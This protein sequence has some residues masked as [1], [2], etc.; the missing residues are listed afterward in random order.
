M[1]LC[2]LWALMVAFPQ[3]LRLPYQGAHVDDDEISWIANNTEKLKNDAVRGNDHLECWTIFSTRRF[4][5]ANKVPQENIPPKK[6]E[7]TTRLLLAAF[8][9]I[10][11]VEEEKVKPVFSKV[12]LWGAAVPMNCLKTADR[13]VFDSRRNVGVCGDWL[14]T[15]CIQGAALSGL[16]L[17][18]KVKAHVGGECFLS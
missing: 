3:P 12:Q 2:S 10:T 16:A 6:A 15:P 4:G 13:C 14:V 11:G 1:Q 7:L 17:A 8:K 9:R 18:E 5:T